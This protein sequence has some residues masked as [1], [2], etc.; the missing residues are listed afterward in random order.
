[1]L[2]FHFF[3]SWCM[4]LSS[5]RKRRSLVGTVFIKNARTG[6]ITIKERLFFCPPP[7]LGAQ[8]G[9][10]LGTDVNELN[11][12]VFSAEKSQA[13]PVSPNLVGAV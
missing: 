10:N 6:H 9:L 4:P 1:M 2:Q 13:A 8:R 3:R 5:I 12:T 7:P 11:V